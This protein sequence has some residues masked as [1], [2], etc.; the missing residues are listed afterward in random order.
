MT[1]LSIMSSRDDPSDIDPRDLCRPLPF[2][3]LMALDPVSEQQ[4]TTASDSE[5]V[6]IFRSR[7]VPFAPGDT[8][9]TFGGHVFAQSAYAASKTVEREL[10]LHVICLLS[11]PKIPV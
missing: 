11:I 10:V 5:K 2:A 7:A 1:A 3:Q 9:R 4:Q 8:F 6:E